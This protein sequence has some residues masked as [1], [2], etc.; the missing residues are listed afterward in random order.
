[1][2]G[3]SDKLFGTE[4]EQF[5]RGIGQRRK[6]TIKEKAGIKSYTPDDMMNMVGPGVPV[7][8]MTRYLKAGTKIPDVARRVEGTKNFLSKM[9]ILGTDAHEA[10]QL[11]AQRYPRIAA[12]FGVDYMPASMQKANPTAHAFADVGNR[13][14]GVFPE[15]TPVLM[16]KKA[17]GEGQRNMEDVLL[18]EGTHVAQDL[19]NKNTFPMYMASKLALKKLG[20]DDALSYA[21]NPFEISARTAASRK[22]GEKVG[23]YSA[24]KGVDKLVEKLP[25]GSTERLDLAKLRRR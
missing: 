12:H 18:H 21:A 17:Y 13:S 20:A 23:P 2:P 5:A 9:K 14:K 3:W 16:G 22:L 4:K 11:F 15:Q 1:M 7:A 6:E 24:L 25:A 8:G 19:G 10:G